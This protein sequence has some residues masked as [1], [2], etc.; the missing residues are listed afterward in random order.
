MWLYLVSSDGSVLELF[1][2]HEC[3]VVVL[4]EPLLVQPRVEAGQGF[5][6]TVNVN[7]EKQKE[8]FQNLNKS[9]I[10]E[11]QFKTKIIRKLLQLIFF[12]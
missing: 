9:L 1:W 2:D 7:L 12:F 8:K 6:A 11:W 10:D 4:E 5:S 3:G